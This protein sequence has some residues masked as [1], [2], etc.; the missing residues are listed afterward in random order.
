[1]KFP[2]LSVYIPLAIG[3]VSAI[4]FLLSVSDY[5]RNERRM[6][7]VGRIRLRMGL[8]FAAVAVGLSILQGV[9]RG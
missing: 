4:F 5:Y 8:I 6:T 7:L 3:A 9:L 1:M 2:N